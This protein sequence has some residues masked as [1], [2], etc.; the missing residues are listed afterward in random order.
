MRLY[1]PKTDARPCPS[2]QGGRAPRPQRISSRHQLALDMLAQNGAALPHGWIAGDDE[3]GRPYWFRRRLIAWGT[4]YAA[5]PGNTLM[6][7]LEARPQRPRR[8]R[9][10]QRPWQGLDPWQTALPAEAWTTI[11]VRDGPKDRWSLTSSTGGWWR[12]PH[13]ARKAR[14]DDGRD[15]VS[16]TRHRPVSKSTFISPM[17]DETARNIC[18]RG[19]SG[20][21]Y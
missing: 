11:D 6:R 15:T 12:A 2:G 5:V 16:R 14:G 20:T 1:L 19:Q 8:S 10:P 13:S 9:R 3:M 17:T 4:V 18:P 21:S 7:D